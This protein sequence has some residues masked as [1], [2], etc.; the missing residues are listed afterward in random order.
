MSVEFPAGFEL[1]RLQREHPRNRF[2]S[3]Q[4]KVDDWLATKALQH[5]TK[6]LSVT[7]VLLDES[8]SIVGFYTLASGQIDC[9]DLPPEVARHL[10]RRTLPVAILAWMGV[11]EHCRGAGLGGRLLAQALR[12]CFDAAATFPFVAVVLDCIDDR[13]KSFYEQW[14]FAEMPG[15]P[16]RL[17][18]SAK[19][20][21]ALMQPKE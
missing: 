10:P 1:Q 16:Y 2:R 8:N 6:R 15:N 18:L 14:H 9:S 7:K 4:P 13:A 19:L 3:G 17:F 21:D 12:D 11:A 20:L 5:Q